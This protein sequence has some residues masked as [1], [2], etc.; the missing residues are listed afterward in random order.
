MPINKAEAEYQYL[1]TR[2]FITTWEAIINA[3]F[4][5]LHQSNGNIDKSFIL[6]VYLFLYK[7]VGHMLM[8]SEQQKQ[9][10]LAFHHR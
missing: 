3:G 9:Q 6:P 8:Q 7:G 5:N 10:N 1:A 2:K 4:S